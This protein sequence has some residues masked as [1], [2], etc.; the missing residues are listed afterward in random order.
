VI[1]RGEIGI[2]RT[3]RILLCLLRSY[4]TLPSR[5][6]TEIFESHSLSL[7]PSLSPSFPVSAL[8]PFPLTISRGALT[9][10]LETA[11]R[12]RYLPQRARLIKRGFAA[13]AGE[14]FNLFSPSA[15]MAAVETGAV[16]CQGLGGLPRSTST[17]RRV[18][19]GLGDPASH[20]PR[21]SPP[22]NPAASLCVRQSRLSQ[23]SGVSRF[24]VQL[25]ARP[26]I[27]RDSVQPLSLSL[28]LL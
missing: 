11:G 26:K 24:C 10:F 15:L 14:G 9:L 23:L 13:A 25:L 2:A 3:R 20:P 5:T 6:R 27:L 22:S 17:T 21:P 28:S 18:Y 16:L 12:R 7:S 19:Q 1:R 4:S 8:S